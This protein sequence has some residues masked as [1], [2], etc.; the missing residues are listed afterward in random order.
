MER[1]PGGEI[2]ALRTCWKK[3]GLS[4]TSSATRILRL[5]TCPLSRCRMVPSSRGLADTTKKWVIR[6][7][8]LKQQPI[9]TATIKRFPHPLSTQSRKKTTTFLPGLRILDQMQEESPRI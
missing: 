5:L 7:A 8:W 3:N 4:R 6:P 9:W 2:S 1:I